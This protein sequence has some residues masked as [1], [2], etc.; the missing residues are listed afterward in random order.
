[1]TRV[2][3][4]RPAE[5]SVEL[6]AE[7]QALGVDCL[8]APMIEIA[9]RRGASLDLDGAQGLLITSANGM[10]AAAALTERRDLDIYAVGPAS[11][12]VAR[13]LGFTRVRTAG[14]DVASLA[15]L[16]AAAADPAAGRLVHAAGSE[17]A[18]DLAGL[19][20]ARGFGVAR[21]VLYQAVAAARL[22]ETARRALASGA[23]D[24]IL[25]FSPRTARTFVT[26]AAAAGVAPACASVTALCLSQA[27]ADAAASCPWRAV[28]V[29]ARP[30]RKALVAL[31]DP[32]LSAA[33]SGGA[34][35]DKKGC[36]G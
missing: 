23:L 32:G 34:G 19:L 11:A 9:P 7:L 18:G 8:V 26:L 21:A 3:I 12:A 22:P 28:R 17:V 25:F 31:L 16:V 36:D 27:V 24:A 30:D 15:H 20:A 1:M 35:P 14:G 13:G 10:R 33:N 29:A 2:L 5:D 4:T 6:A